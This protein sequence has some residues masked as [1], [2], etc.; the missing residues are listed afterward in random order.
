MLADARDELA[1][2]RIINGPDSRGAEQAAV[3]LAG[4][5]A[6][7][8]TVPAGVSEEQGTAPPVA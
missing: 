1:A 8:A 5:A 4:L 2:Q 6:I 7:A 3:N